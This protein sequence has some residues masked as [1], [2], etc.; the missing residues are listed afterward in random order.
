MRT[1]VTRGVAVIVWLAG[2][3]MPVLAVEPVPGA[4]L[5]ELLTLARAA[6]PDYASV[7]L[8]ADAANERIQPAGALPD[9]KFRIEWMDIDQG[10]TQSPS[11][12][13]GNVGS[14][15]YTWMQDLPWFGKRGLKRDVAQFEAQASAGKANGTW[16]ELAA[17]LK[18]VQAQRDYLQ[19]NQAFIEDILG[20]MRRLEQVAQVR[21][22]GGLAMQQD[23]IRAQLEQTAMRAELLALQAERRQLDAQLNALLARGA[24]E[25]LALPDGP[26]VLPTPERLDVN[27]LAERLREHNPQLASEAARVQAAE[28]GKQL[29]SLNRYPDFN[30][31]VSPTQKQN[32]LSEWGVMLELNIPLQQDSRRAQEREAQALLDAAQARTEALRHQ[33]QSD[34]SQNL[35]AL[36]AARATEALVSANLLPQAEL[37]WQSALASYENGKL[38]FATLIDAQRQLRQARQSQIKARL[39]AQMRLAEVEKLIGEEL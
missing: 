10:G 20:L 15:K 38:D 36:D 26:R 2:A 14:V 29:T 18:S 21:Y 1:L 4:D 17:R 16:A 33:L 27:L 9:P 28:K 19:R 22:A 34:L 12:L 11:L 5:T 13:P 23:V 31:S 6:N 8:E 7:R 39:E 25:P 24:N 37:G 32:N 35:A 30:L 3:S